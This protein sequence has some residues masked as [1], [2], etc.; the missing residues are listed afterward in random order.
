MTG[1]TLW[2]FVIN[3]AI[4]AAGIGAAWSVHFDVAAI[5]N[6]GPY[7]FV[8][9]V[10]WILAM[11]T[12]GSFTQQRKGKWKQVG[13]NRHVQR[14]FRSLPDKPAAQR[15]VPRARP[16]AQRRRGSQSLR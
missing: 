5:E 1:K 14:S 11:T 16:V 13:R 7:F 3:I 2:L 6:M 12:S 15:R 10:V 9:A 4:L 8:L